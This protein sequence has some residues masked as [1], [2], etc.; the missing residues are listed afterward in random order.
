MERLI[1]LA[2]TTAFVA[3]AY[4]VTKKMGE[5]THLKVVQKIHCFAEEKVK[6][7]YNLTVT[8]HL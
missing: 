8:H 7:G 3:G 2:V 5:Q 4:Y 6:Q 1:S